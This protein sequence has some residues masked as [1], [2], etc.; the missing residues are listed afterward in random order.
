[1]IE[2]RYYVRRADT[3]QRGWMYGVYDG[4]NWR[5]IG[6]LYERRPQAQQRVDKL[7]GDERRFF[8][9]LAS[10]TMLDPLVT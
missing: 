10:P 1:M 2:D 5:W 9:K 4:K 7:N 3:W 8:E 6:R